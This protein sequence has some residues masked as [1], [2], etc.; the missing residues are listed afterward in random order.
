MKIFKIWGRKGTT[1]AFFT[2]EIVA[3][4]LAQANEKLA[5]L[6]KQG[7][8]FDGDFYNLGKLPK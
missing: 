6:K 5:N 3:K 7:H 1:G 8:T 4:N 2:Y